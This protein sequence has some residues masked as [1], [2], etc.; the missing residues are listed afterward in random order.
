MPSP[1]RNISA[2]VPLILAG[3]SL[4]GSYG[5]SKN[6]NNAPADTTGSPFISATAG[7]SAFSSTAVVGLEDTAN[8]RFQ[9]QGTEVKDGDTSIL[10]IYFPNSIYMPV[11]LAFDGIT[12]LLAYSDPGKAQNYFQTPGS[13]S[14]ILT[15]T[16]INTTTHKIY[17]NFSGNVY[18]NGSSS[19][20]AFAVNN[21]SFYA[22]YTMP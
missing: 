15:I 19:D 4:G 22:T 17:G 3:L 1:L 21:G 13:S 16:G 11:T 2:F 8:H 7:S 20:S 6:S 10:T 5:C 12:T 18:K 14:G 9:I